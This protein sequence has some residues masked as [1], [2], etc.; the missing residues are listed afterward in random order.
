MWIM[1]ALTDNMDFQNWTIYLV[2]HP[3]A[4]KWVI[5]PVING[6]SRVNPLITGVTTHLLSGMSHQVGFWTAAGFVFSSTKTRHAILHV[7]LVTLKQFWGH[8]PCSSS[9]WHPWWH[10]PSLLIDPCLPVVWIPVLLQLE[11]PFFVAKPLLCSWWIY[12][13]CL[14]LVARSL[15]LSHLIC[16]GFKLSQVFRPLGQVQERSTP[17]AKWSQGYTP[18]RSHEIIGVV[19]KIYVLVGGLEHVLLPWI[20]E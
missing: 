4:R 16:W 2:A 12:R 7:Q 9:S 5:T 11:S 13:I 3:T 8:I 1:V 19:E 6:I 14:D 15:P 10:P 18:E 17:E 20:N